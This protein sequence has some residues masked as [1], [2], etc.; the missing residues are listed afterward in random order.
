MHGVEARAPVHSWVPSACRR[1]A[2]IAP[3]MGSGRSQ[4]MHG[5]EA[6]APVHSGALAATS[7]NFAA[8]RRTPLHKARPKNAR[9]RGESARALLEPS[10][11][12]RNAPIA[13]NIG[14]NRSQNMHRVEARAPAH[15]GALAATSANFAA[16]RRTPL[17][18]ARPK[19]AWRRGE[20]ARALLGA[21]RVQAKRPDSTRHRKRPKPKYAPRRGESA[22]ALRC[23]RGNFR[24]LRRQTADPPAQGE[25]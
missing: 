1:K 15:S 16:R 10:A 18:K 23:T 22:R 17:H 8:S 21:L 11:C 6:R 7:A 12:R 13:S 4:N 3:G 24:E 20:S 5:V 19:N 25:T 9:R 14:S 2:P